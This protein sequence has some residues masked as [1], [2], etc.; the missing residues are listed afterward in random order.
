MTLV[1]VATHLRQLT[2][3]RHKRDRRDDQVWLLEHARE[4]AEVQRQRVR[5]L[6]RTLPRDML[7]ALGESAEDIRL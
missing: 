3:P 6:Q 1:R 5:L 2:T 7:T 4:A